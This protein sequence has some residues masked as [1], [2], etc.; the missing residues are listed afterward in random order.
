M[1]HALA[2]ASIGTPPVLHHQL[3]EAQTGTPLCQSN[4]WT[5]SPLITGRQAPAMRLHPE[6]SL[7]FSPAF[8]GQLRA[9][10]PAPNQVRRTSP[11]P[12]AALRVV[13]NRTAMV[14]GTV[15]CA[16]RKCPGPRLRETRTP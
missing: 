2:G 8:A 7:E 12:K 6:N 15:Y 10:H 13:A 14:P 16:G 11:D 1:R 4:L 5:F 3:R 9:K